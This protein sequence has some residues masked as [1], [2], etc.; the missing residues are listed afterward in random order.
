MAISKA[1]LASGLSL[2]EIEYI[3]LAESYIDRIIRSQWKGQI[4]VVLTTDYFVEATGKPRQPTDQELV[5]VME[6]FRRVGWDVQ[7][8]MAGT[9]KILKFG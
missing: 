3:V 7:S 5:I 2:E 4:P 1:L 8:E 6:D 9:T